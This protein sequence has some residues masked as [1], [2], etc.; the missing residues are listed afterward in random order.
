MK[1]DKL[2]QD[3]I[4]A[5]FNTDRETALDYVQGDDRLDASQ[6][7]GIYRGSV[8]CILTQS[9]GNTFP[10]CKELLGEEFFDKMCDRFID[11]YPPSTP[12]FSHY[13]DNLSTFLNDF[14]P[15]KTISFISDVAAFEWSR[16]KLW[17]QIPSKPFDYSQIA[18]LNEEQQAKIVFK[19]SRSLHLFQSD[20]RIDLI[21]FAHQDGSDIELEDIE[22]NTE[23]NLLMWKGNKTIKI[24]NLVTDDS[25]DKDV[26]FSNNFSDN[27]TN[28]EYWK[29]LKAVSNKLNITELAAE[30]DAQF[31]DLLNKSIQ[32]GWIESF[33]CD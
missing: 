23:I 29:F 13:G 22:I 2:Q 28:K 21:W 14:D 15:V 11:K 17:Q 10:V 27:F 30:F 31:P 18:T 33:T 16:H 5:I 4:A 25:A 3:F 8:H 1:L 32:D 7:L 6:R 24:A 26:S 12:F 19:L 9:L 20:Y